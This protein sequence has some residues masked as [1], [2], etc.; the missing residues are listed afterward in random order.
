MHACSRCTDEEGGTE[1]GVGEGER[2]ERV[3]HKHT[4]AVSLE[5]LAA[6]QVDLLKPPPLFE[7][8]VLSGVRSR[9]DAVQAKGE[10]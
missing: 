3:V 9:A 7:L 5:V 1:A 10:R 8:E 2:A 6:V 4:Q